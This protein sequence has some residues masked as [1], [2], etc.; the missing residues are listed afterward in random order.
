MAV[1][2]AV[3]WVF[4]TFG[5]GINLVLIGLTQFGLFVFA[6]TPWLW[7][8]ADLTQRSRNLGARSVAK[9]I[10]TRVRQCWNRDFINPSDHVAKMECFSFLRGE[11]PEL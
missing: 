11:Q 6:V 3:N 10:E 4:P 9:T 8:D 1:S 7:A 2:L 5:Y